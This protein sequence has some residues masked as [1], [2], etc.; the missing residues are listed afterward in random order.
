MYK[1]GFT[2]IEL[3]VVISIIGLL[4]SIV[5]ASLKSARDKAQIAAGQR[6]ST[7]VHRALAAYS[8]GSWSLE[9]VNG[10]V[11]TD[12][13]GYKKDLTVHNATVVDGVIGN[14]LRFTGLETSYAQSLPVTFTSN[15]WTVAVWIKPTTDVGGIFLTVNSLPYLRFTSS[16]FFWSWSNGVQQRHE[17]TIN[18][19]LNQ[20]Y[21][22]AMAST[23]SEIAMYVNG[24]EVERI[25]SVSVIPP[26]GPVYIGKFRS[27]GYATNADIDEVHVFNEV[28]V[29]SEIQKM[30]AQGLPKHLAG[31]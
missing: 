13:S 10:G 4:S 8:V 12:S 26:S 25:A 17:E 14:A 9:S 22:V 20:W 28:L 19:K 21:H 6:F 2:L 29:A 1:K 18:R 27:S 15:K 3:L 23:G 11:S 16:S 5:L 30:Y 31:I 7:H 24:Q